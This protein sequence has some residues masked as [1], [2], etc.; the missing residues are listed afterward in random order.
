[1][2]FK[3]S[4]I[5]AVKQCTSEKLVVG[6]RTGYGWYL[7]LVDVYHQH[8]PYQTGGF[9]IA[10]HFNQAIHNSSHYLSVSVIKEV[11]GRKKTEK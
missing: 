5:A 8:Q 1:M 7:C 4:L 2:S 6:S 11:I 9:P 10:E 3:Q